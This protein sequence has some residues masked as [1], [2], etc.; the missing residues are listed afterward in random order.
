[1]QISRRGERIVGI[2]TTYDPLKKRGVQSIVLSFKAYMTSIESIEGDDKSREQ[3][4]GLRDDERAQLDAWLAEASERQSNY[5]SSSVL[6]GLVE[7]V[8]KA[9]DA[10]ESEAG[11]AVM[12]QER[13]DAIYHKIRD[14]QQSLKAA[15]YKRPKLSEV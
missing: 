13:A 10:L 6:T 4:Q 14:L 12:N 1:M 15:G 2:R 9:I 7:H 11:R 3:L 8:G 5:R